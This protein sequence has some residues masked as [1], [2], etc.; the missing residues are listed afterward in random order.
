MDR[1]AEVTSIV[2]HLSAAEL[3][4]S[5][6]ELGET[7]NP[8]EAIADAWELDAVAERYREFATRFGRLCPKTP[9]PPSA[10]SRA[11]VHT[12]RKFPFLDPDLP[13]EMLPA[14]WPRSRAHQAFVDRHGT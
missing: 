1:E 5:R 14:Q 10:R 9:E 7:G 8:A 13:Q 12:W 4:S 6:A 3:F 2:R 11:L